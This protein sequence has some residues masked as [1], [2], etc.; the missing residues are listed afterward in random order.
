MAIRALS[1]QPVNADALALMI[2]FAQDHPAEFARLADNLSRAKRPRHGML[3]INF[4]DY[5][6]TLVERKETWR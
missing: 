4:A 3:A 5:V 2:E 1:M 6:P